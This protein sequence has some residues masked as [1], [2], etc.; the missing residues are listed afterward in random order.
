MI[1]E[2]PGHLGSR[3]FNLSKR[4]DYCHELGAGTARP[5][6]QLLLTV[7]LLCITA[8]FSSFSFVFGKEA[9]EIKLTN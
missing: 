1:L 8:Y 2:E 4:F 9:M 5:C 7:S 6:G 3:L